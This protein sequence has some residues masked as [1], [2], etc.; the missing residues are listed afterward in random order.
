MSS[1]TRRR[2][3]GAVVAA[4]AV[5]RRRP[6]NILFFFPDQHRFDWTGMNPSLD[7]R[8]P[9]LRSVAE[10]GVW[11]DRA[12]VASPLCAP[13]RAALASGRDYDRCG[14]PNNGADYPLDQPTVYRALREAG[15]Y[16][17]GCGKFDLHKKSFVWGPEGKAFLQ[18]WGF[19]DGI[20][21]AGK[22]DAVSS[23]ALEP[24]DPYMTYLESR[25]L[26]LAHVA[27]F[28]RRGGQAHYAD[29]RPTPLDDEAYCDN[30]I[31]RNGLGLLRG[32]PR[33]GPWFLMV[34]FAGPHS[35]MDITESMERGL[36]ARWFPPPTLS[37]EFDAA[38]HQAIRQNYTAMV[39]NIDRWLG[40]F[41]DEVR[42]RGELANTLVVYSSDHGEMLGDLNRWAK[43]VPYQPAIGVPLALAGPGVQPGLRSDA[44]VSHIDLT[45]TFLTAAGLRVPADMDSRPLQPVLSGKA[46]AHR[47]FVRSGLN[48]WRAVWD[49]RYKLVRGFPPGKPDLLFDHAADPSE[50]TD[51]AAG[52]PDAVER[53]RRLLPTPG[54]S[55]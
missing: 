8:T 14:V 5:L 50:N 53:L 1:A 22:G 17:A 51:F 20:D 3:L 31:A 46:R 33:R 42:Q 30:W 47:E 25:G 38:T 7:V 39:E 15:Y 24:K 52:Q 40:V 16:V 23:G 21:N 6:P 36:R 4:P 49:G 45:A 35:P 2:F 55:A 9:H 48:Q 54:R 44:L 37:T 11:F 19:T 34:N 32:A 29:T 27:D 13:S 26:R 43:S 10:R 18:E 28:R 12:V 41:L